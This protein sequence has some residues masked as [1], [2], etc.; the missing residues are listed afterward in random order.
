MV[1]PKTGFGLII[2][3]NQRLIAMLETRVRGVGG[4]EPTACEREQ[5]ASGSGDPACRPAWRLCSLCR[6]PV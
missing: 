4:R 2:S 6:V 1:A 3:Q 5:G